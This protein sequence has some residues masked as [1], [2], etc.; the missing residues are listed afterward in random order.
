MCCSSV[1]PILCKNRGIGSFFGSRL[2]EKSF[3]S[4]F[5]G[6]ANKI[7]S[8]GS[9]EDEADGIKALSDILHGQSSALRI[10]PELENGV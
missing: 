2:G 9:G 5:E 8:V 4:R 6:E 3:A 1:N 10:N 7:T